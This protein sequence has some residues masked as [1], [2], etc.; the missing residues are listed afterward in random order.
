[1]NKEDSDALKH[2]LDDTN[3]SF[4]WPLGDLTRLPNELSVAADVRTTA[5]PTASASAESSATST[6][7][8][9][10]TA[11]LCGMGRA[12]EA[13]RHEARQPASCGHP[14]PTTTTT[15]GHLTTPSQLQVASP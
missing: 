11:T 12:G 6:T 9:A 14:A 8:A 15:A 3:V 1:M 2:Y 7:A 4:V 10:M 5:A 13:G